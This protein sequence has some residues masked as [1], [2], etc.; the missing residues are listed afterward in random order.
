MKDEPSIR[1]RAVMT[2]SLTAAGVVVML[3]LSFL[4][5]LTSV[6]TISYSKLEELVA[7][8]AVTEVTIGADAI[9]GKL[10]NPLPSGKSAFTTNRHDFGRKA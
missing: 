10:K 2:A 9:E 1:N 5:V 4:A 3:L 7:Q 8:G 6:E